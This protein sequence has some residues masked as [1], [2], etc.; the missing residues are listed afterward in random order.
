MRLIQTKDYDAMSAYAADMVKQQIKVKEDTILGLA[1]GSS[2]IGIYEKLSEEYRNGNM[3]LAK[4]IGFNLD[5]YKSLSKKHKQSFYFFLI[6]RLVKKTDF[7]T[8]NLNVLDG[9]SK[10]IELECKKFDNRIHDVGGIDL[11]ILGIGRTGHI[12]FNE[13]ADFFPDGSHCVKLEEE[14][15]QS[16]S[17]FFDSLDEV[18]RYALTMG[19]GTIMRAKKILMLV[20]GTSKAEILDQM[21]HGRVTPKI[22]A[23]ILQ[24]HPNVTVIADEAACS[25]INRRRL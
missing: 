24:F 7:K 18:P 9:M 4:V 2:P 23:S 10:D 15:I 22:P 8:D 16:N 17:R 11:Q 12:G 5:E 19:I 6:E 20:S 14:T 21:I 3:S 1:T 13:P 25:V